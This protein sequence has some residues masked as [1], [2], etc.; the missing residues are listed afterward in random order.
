MRESS[1]NHSKG[2]KEE[3]QSKLH[4]TVGT[5]GSADSA[6]GGVTERGIRIAELRRIKEIECLGAEFDT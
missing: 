5:C 2:L 1:Q 6:E 3:S 4:L